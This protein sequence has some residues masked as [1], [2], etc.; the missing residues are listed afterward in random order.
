MKVAAEADLAALEQR[1]G[2]RFND[3]DLLLTALTHASAA[4]PDGVDYQRFEFLGDRVLGLAVAEMLLEEFPKATE[5]EMS[6]RFADLVRG[7]TC[8]TVAAELGIDKVV[9]AGGGKSQQRSVLTR[10]V[11]SDVCEAVIAA[12][13]LDGGYAAA[14][15]FVVAN[16]RQRME[17]ARGARNNAKTVLQEWAQAKGLP[18]PTYTIAGKTGPD[19]D[20]VFAVEVSVETVRPARGE[21]RS[22]REAEQDAAEVI[23]VRE[24]V[25]DD[26]R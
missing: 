1:I 5:G 18:P 9:R 26:V 24:R 20:S 21:G 16:W 12:I 2:Y 4:S 17:S 10:N 15:E 6:P 3:R 19:H 25:W 7:Q 8:A 23:L 13:F 11:L 14:R 22:R